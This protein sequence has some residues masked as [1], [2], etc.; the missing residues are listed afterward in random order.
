MVSNGYFK[1]D[2]DAVLSAY[3]VAAEIHEGEERKSELGGPYLRHPLEVLEKLIRQEHDYE[4]LA[5]G[6]LHDTVENLLEKPGY[7]KKNDCLDYV[8]GALRSKLNYKKLFTYED[9]S[10]DVRKIVSALSKDTGM[11][12][13][14]A[15]DQIFRLDELNLMR[16]LIIK[17]TDRYLNTLDTVGYEPK[18]KE[19]EFYKTFVIGNKAKWYMRDRMRFLKRAGYRFRDACSFFR[20]EKI[21]IENLKRYKERRDDQAEERDYLFSKIEE[22]FGDLVIQTSRVIE[23]SLAGTKSGFGDYLDSL[24]E[25]KMKRKLKKF[26]AVREDIEKYDRKGGFNRVT[27]PK[28]GSDLDG[29]MIFYLDII[30]HKE[31][32]ADYDPNF[33]EQYRKLLIFQK[34]FEKVGSEDFRNYFLRGLDRKM[35]LI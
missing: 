6:I 14:E 30:S 17:C 16:A 8:I 11:D 28:K 35:L 26:E 9:R 34:L 23:D 4:T 18:E 32:R 33:F 2:I 25:K 10:D 7:E 15:N 13:F 24:P 31:K 21:S 5:A 29:T 22:T 19:F 1:N 3:E 12:F 20:K 27:K